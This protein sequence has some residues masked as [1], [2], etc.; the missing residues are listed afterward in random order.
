MT[1]LGPMFELVTV[2]PAILKLAEIELKNNPNDGH[3]KR[4]RERFIR[5]GLSSLNDYEVVEL[6]LTL[7]TPRSD[8]K[9][10]AKDLLD[11]FKTLKR[12]L[13]ASSEE[14][15]QVK[16]VGPVNTSTRQTT[17]VVSKHGT[18]TAAT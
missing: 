6:I 13:E 5:A 17:S 12:V 4:L 16:G 18:H 7:G 2:V 11:R 8:C 3:R 14:L 10:Q 1:E 15:Q 9:Q